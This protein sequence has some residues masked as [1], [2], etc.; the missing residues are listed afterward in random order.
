MY[1]A[2]STTVELFNEK[3]EL[4]KLEALSMHNGRPGLVEFRL[5]DPHA[6]ESR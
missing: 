6:A 5:G 2:G 3:G 4:G 1:Q